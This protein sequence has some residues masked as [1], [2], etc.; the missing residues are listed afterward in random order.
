M[1]LLCYPTS[2]KPPQIRPASQRRAWMDAS[3]NGYAYRCLPLTIANSHGWEILS[4]EDHEAI[5]NGGPGTKDITCRST[6][7]GRFRVMSH[8]GSGI[9]TF[10]I[11]CLFRTDPAVNL[12]VTGPLNAPKD[13]IAPLPGIVETDW[14]TATF[15][16]NWLFTR[17]NHVVRFAK[18]EPI[19]F[20]FPLARGLIE[21]AEPE[22]RALE[23]DPALHA[24]Y[25][26]WRESRSQFLKD[27]PHPGT[28]A[29]QQKWQKAY[30]RGELP[31]G[32]PGSEAHQTKLQVKEFVD[33][34]AAAAP[35]PGR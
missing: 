18:D 4:A 2:G 13:G 22:I 25:Q 28:T 12:M 11:G 3:P 8:F 5:W 7:D 24:D 17:P 10:D 23:S 21:S 6:G 16:M 20:I 26:R 29:S 19:C 34:S 15:T 31:G 30:F 14:A 27:L 9:I 32:S 33:R 1:R 35:K